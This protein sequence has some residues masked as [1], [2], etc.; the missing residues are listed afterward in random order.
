LNRIEIRDESC[1]G[2]QYCLIF[3]P[4]ELLQIDKS[5]I[6]VLG[7]NPA[8]FVDNPEK[9]C[10]GCALCAEICPD[11]LIEVYRKKKG[12]VKA[13]VRTPNT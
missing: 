5:R 1:K 9:P 3:C 13:N 4:R 7:Y 11:A 12:A 6:N 8:R 10:L 2:C